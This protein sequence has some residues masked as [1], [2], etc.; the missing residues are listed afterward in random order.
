MVLETDTL[1]GP[2]GVLQFVGVNLRITNSAFVSLTGTPYTLVFNNSV[3]E[4]DGTNFESNSGARTVAM[5][6]PVPAVQCIAHSRAWHEQSN[7]C[8]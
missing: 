2:R 8:T 7:V 5:A 1:P 3:V 4:I 6:T